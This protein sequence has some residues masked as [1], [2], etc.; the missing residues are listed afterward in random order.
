MLRN[1]LSVGGITLLSRLTGF[2]R[3]VIMAAVIG[4]GPLMDAFST[5]FR[6]PNH[7]RA[8]FGEGA[9][10]AAY[11]PAYTQIRIK[12]GDEQ[13]AA[14]QGRMLT[15]L[16]VATG[17]LTLV[18]LYFTPQ[19][20]NLLAPGFER[21]PERYRLAIELTRI[22]FPYL[23]LIT[24]VTLWSGALNAAGRF[25]AAA[26]APILLNVSLIGAMYLA[27]WF[28]TAGHAAAWAVTASGLFQLAL[29]AV[30]AQR[31]GILALPRWPRRDADLGLFFR[32]FVPAV[33]GAAGTQIAMFADTII[34]TLLPTGAPS[35]IYYAD[36]IYQLPIGVIAIAAGTVLLPEMSRRFASGDI[37][38]AHAAQNRVV[39]LTA[40]MTLPF[41][42]AFLLLAE[43]IMLGAFG[44]GKFDLAAAESAGA[45]LAAYGVGLPA[46]VLIRA[47]VSGFQARGDTR[48]P[49]VVAL[50]AV[51]CNVALKLVLTG[52]LG[53]P[54][55]ALATSAGAWVNLLL[56]VVIGC[57]R[58][59]MAPDRALLKR[60]G[61]GLFAALVLA[62]AT[63]WL[64]APLRAAVAQLP[65]FH[66]ESFLML[67]GC[68]G[69]AIYAA[70]L[71]V[72][73]RIVG[74]PLRRK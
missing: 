33:I 60:L 29:L 1:F 51:A 42:V 30:A 49:M 40:L 52:P 64:A 53:T 54:G 8:I 23:M 22:T 36:R 44:R 19:V 13:A 59:W 18:A 41:A 2:A 35:A 31:A 12:Q 37:D 10:S 9:F 74:T 14:F 16:I 45:V 21:T 32:R 28:D 6:L 27:G 15:I 5:A 61:A 4:A 26:F 55:L 7:F 47:A 25:V 11:I 73:L 65:R 46:I 56:L 39:A 57:R 3:D 71:L 20:I 48:T 67:I 24:V 66:A 34:A 72:A 68:A 50:I 63:P 70:T 69:A 43:P 58:G 62:G 17:L 38:G